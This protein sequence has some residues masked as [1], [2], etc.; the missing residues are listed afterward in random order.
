M[1]A[2]LGCHSCSTTP[3]ITSFLPPYMQL[4][5]MLPCLHLYCRMYMYHVYH[6][7]LHRIA[8][9]VALMSPL[10]IKIHPPPPDVLAVCFQMWLLYSEP[11][12]LSCKA[13]LCYF[14]PLALVLPTPPSLVA[15][16]NFINALF[17]LSPRLLIKMLNKLR[18]N[19]SHPCS[20][21]KIP[22]PS[23][24]CCC[25]SLAFVYGPSASFQSMR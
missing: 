21:H 7:L 9:N 19:Q 10:C 23:S 3:D 25:L 15:S 16:V 5:I 13:S 4:T 11:S 20:V 18:P 8:F 24:M 22:P 14:S 12:P 1:G 17:T 6:P 2:E